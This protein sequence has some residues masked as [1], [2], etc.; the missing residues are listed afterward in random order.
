MNITILAVTKRYNSVCIAGINEQRKWIRPTKDGELDLRN[1]SVGRNNYISINNIYDFTF[2]RHLPIGC[3]T[4][5]YIIDESKYIS[6]KSRL[7]DSQ[8]EKLFSQLAE[9]SLVTSNP[10][11]NI[12]EILRSN[13]RSLVLLGPVRI[14]RVYI[15][16]NEYMR[17]PKV[18][19][20]V[21]SINVKGPNNKTDLPCT[22]LKFRALAKS[23]LRKEKTNSL[24]LNENR[25][26]QL[27]GFNQVF[28]VVGL[29]PRNRLPSGL[30]DNWPMIIGVHTLPDYSQDI[31]YNDL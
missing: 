15:Y 2:S 26:K 22:D 7:T 1:I 17:T 19:F 11:K 12:T 13:K 16:I 18:T 28:I 5:N 10:T 14:E 6:H 24:M 20:S 29:T 30:V 3:Q 9:N 8:R 25:L 27:L 31:D 4:E 23:L 21:N